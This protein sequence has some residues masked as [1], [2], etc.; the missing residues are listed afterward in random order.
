[1]IGEIEGKLREY[2]GVEVSKECIEFQGNV[3]CI[4]CF[5]A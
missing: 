1:M 3:I 5:D 4:R 2:D